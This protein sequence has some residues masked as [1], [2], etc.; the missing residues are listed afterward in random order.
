MPPLSKLKP[1][2]ERP[3]HIKSPQPPFQKGVIFAVRYSSA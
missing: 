2:E 3:G 1:F